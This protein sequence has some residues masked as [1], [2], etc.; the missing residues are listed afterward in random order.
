[1]PRAH[2]QLSHF[3][4]AS[5]ASLASWGVFEL[6]KYK[7]DPASSPDRVIGP[8][9]QHHVDAVYRLAKGDSPLEE[10]SLGLWS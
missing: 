10:G 2:S 7:Y 6:V 1:M 3:Q 9:S 8:Q 4:N 5:T